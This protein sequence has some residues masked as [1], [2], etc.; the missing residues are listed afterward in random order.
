Y[1]V[2]RNLP[3]H[4]FFA[5]V[6][7]GAKRGAF[8]HL[9]VE[10]GEALR[11]ALADSRRGKDRTIAAA[12]ADNHVSALIEELDVRVDA[13]HGDDAVGRVQGGEIE[14]R[15][16][17]EPRDRV[18][19]CDAPSQRI[20]APLR[21]EITDTKPGQPVL[22]GKVPDNADEQIDPAVSGGVPGRADNH[23]YAEA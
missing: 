14:G 2:H 23:W 10:I 17:V 1:I 5:G 4:R 20:L 11:K 21:M 6:R 3:E 13:C 7:L 12:A 8:E 22:E 19:G 15:P 9:A 16:P 18:A